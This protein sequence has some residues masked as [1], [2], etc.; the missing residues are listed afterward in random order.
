MLFAGVGWV[1]AVWRLPAAVPCDSA[2]SVWRAAISVSMA[3]MVCSSW[4]WLLSG[5][6]VGGGSSPEQATIAT[7][8][9]ADTSARS[10][11]GVLW[12]PFPAVG[13]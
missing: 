9:I 4:G 7:R 3:S 12:T 5:R 2:V 10:I 6:S 8:V 13:R 1:F 11:P